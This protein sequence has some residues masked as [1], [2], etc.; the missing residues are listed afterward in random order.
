[1]ADFGQ[2]RS[3]FRTTN[4]NLIIAADALPRSFAQRGRAASQIPAGGVGVILDS[5]AQATSAT[6]IGRSRTPT[7]EE[8]FTVKTSKGRYQVKSINLTPTE[9]AGYYKGFSNQT[10][11]PLCHVAFQ[12]PLFVS[13]WHRHYRKVNRYFAEAIKESLDPNKHNFVWINDYQLALVPSYLGK[14]ENT[15]VALF[16]HIPWPTWE[17]FR[18]LPYKHEILTSLLN[19]NFLG[20]HRSYHVTNFFQTMERE[21]ETRIDAET[22]TIFYNDRG[23]MVKN[24]P[25]GVDTEAIKKGFRQ[26]NHQFKEYFQKYRVMM[27]V[28]RLDYTKGLKVRLRAIS[29]FF[30]SN[31]KY[32]GKVIY[33]GIIAPSREDIPAYRRI[34]KE[35]EAI[36]ARINAKHRQGDWQPVLLKYDVFDRAAL[37][38]WFSQASVCLVTPLDDG[39]NLVSKEF[40]VASSLSKEPGMLV[41][42][43]FAGSA[44]DL[45]SALIV[46][47]YDIKTVAGAIKESLEMDPE[48][49]KERLIKMTR[50][51]EERNVYQWCSD[52]IREAL[53][54]EA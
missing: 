52:F 19:C 14:L 13:R 51:L 46:N 35:V 7:P 18:I 4:C 24:L 16:W 33:L 8:P 15:T 3:W 23:T 30:S 49:K 12:R 29:R 21:M 53:A 11:W 54:A 26:K 32:K 50:T 9:V 47:P 20:F 48:E 25:L 42:S 31:P 34:K 17:I 10:L 27:G 1:M 45:T 39:M 40:V 44:I 5:I 37:M 43:Q 6:Y 22:K 41:L 36:A 38:R 2:L 28:D